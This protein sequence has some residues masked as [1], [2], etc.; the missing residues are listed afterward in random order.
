MITASTERFR[1]DLPL[2][3]RIALLADFGFRSF[4]VALGGS[5]EPPSLP[6]AALRTHGASVADVTATGGDRPGLADVDEA[7]RERAIEA[8]AST[9]RW[10]RSVRCGVVVVDPGL[11]AVFDA[12]R[13]EEE[14][15]RLVAAGKREAAA[16]F[17]DPLRNG[18]AGTGP[19]QIERLCRSL[20][21]LAQLEPDVRWCLPTPSGPSGIPGPAELGWVFDDLGAVRLGYWHVASRA[22][23]WARMVGD[24]AEAWLDAF[25]SRAAGVVYDDLA[26]ADERLLPGTGELDLSRIAGT[27]PASA[28]R[29][30]PLP[31]DA[32]AIAV[33]AA[34]RYLASIGLE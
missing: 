33:Q 21:R 19:G 15:W 30:L 1:T 24:D 5:S 9:A 32:G 16:E 10:A 29:V 4:E 22:A 34:L 31:A 11:L 12:A 14:A 20:H 17:L 7:R 8:A 23:R 18:R 6:T 26:G 25:G 28:V 13:R 27:V 3:D 2:R